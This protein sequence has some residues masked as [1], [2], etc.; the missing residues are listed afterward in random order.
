[1]SQKKPVILI[2]LGHYTP[3]FK[4]G[5]PIRSI[6]NLVNHLS[7]RFVFRIF[8][9]DRDL[10]DSSPYLGVVPN[11]WCQVG[12]AQVYYASKE[13]LTLL[14]MAKVINR[15]PHD[16][17]YLNSFFS[18]VFSYYILALRKLRCIRRCP[19]ILAP[20]GEFSEGA[21]ALKASKKTA[22]ILICKVLG[23]TN[24]IAW[25]AS[26]VY[27]A[28][29]IKNKFGEKIKVLNASNLPKING[30]LNGSPSNNEDGRL[31]V[32]F[33]SRITPKKNL[34][35][36]LQIMLR[37]KSRIMFSIYGPI[38]DQQYWRKCQEVIK[39]VP[40]NVEITYHGAVPP[41]KVG[42][43]MVDHHLFFLPTYGENY[44]HVIAEAL[45]VGTE[46]L[47]SDQTPWRGLSSKGLG[48]E[49][50][51]SEKGSFVEYVESLAQSDVDYRA[52]RRRDVTA[53]FELSRDATEVEKH[54]DLFCNVLDERTSY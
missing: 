11:E 43:K 54:V 10:G 21:L 29:D 28:T 36:A 51:L 12:E 39:A 19:L 13:R 23:L 35:Y 22:Y 26:S 25:H 45:A 5:G 42:E 27:E 49:F 52:R 32:I 16:L 2:V 41:E 8:T 24:D 15:T 18:P 53:A 1:M 30:R 34:Y 44:G 6:V 38:E 7:D 48:C 31:R 17:I 33:M 47:I 3:G 40:E 46:V 50:P 9:A 37:V 20:R 4:A 14:E